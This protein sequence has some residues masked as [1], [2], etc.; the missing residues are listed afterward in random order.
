MG[1][2]ACLALLTV[3]LQQRWG[4]P[5]AVKA[6]DDLGQLGFA[7][8]AAGLC[9]LAS[10]RSSGR[11]RRS[12]AAL[13]V[14][15]AAWGSGQVVWSYYELAADRA[16]PFP[17]AADAG[18]LI[19]PPAAMLALW[20]YPG[21]GRGAR[22]RTRL[23]L[24]GATVAA[25]LLVLSRV[26]TLGAVL[27]AGGDNAF[28][29]AVS[30]SYPLGDL[31]LLTV[32]ILVLAR[33]TARRRLPLILMSCS[34][35]AM[36][37]ADSAFTYLTSTETYHSG[38]LTDLGWPAAFVLVAIAGLV[39]RPADEQIDVDPMPSRLRMFLPYAA[40]PVAAA[41]VGWQLM[42]GR[43]IST[44]EQVT[45]AVLVT[46]IFVR[47]LVTLAENTQLVAEVKVREEQL[48]HQAF[49]DPLTGLPNRSLFGDRLSHAVELHR[50][51]AR[52]VS[53]VIL[54]LDDFKLVN[55]TLGHPAGDELLIKVAERLLACSRSADTVARLGG[56]EFALLLE[57][58]PEAPQVV[59]RRILDAFS[60]PFG[61]IAG[62]IRMSSSV[63]LV[64]DS[65]DTAELSA[66]NI[67]RDADIA[68]YVAKR[69][70]KGNLAVFTPDMRTLEDD[71]VALRAE[72][73]E[74]IEQGQISVAYQPIRD[75]DTHELWGVEALARWQNGR[76]G[77]LT[78]QRFI[79][80]AEQAGL[81]SAIDDSV[82]DQAIRQY[83]IW[84]RSCRTGHLMLSVNVSASRLAD[85]GYCSF[86][87]AALARHR[88]PADRLIME[89]TESTLMTD[90]DAAISI[91]THLQGLGVSVAIDDFGTGYSSLASLDVLPVNLLKV[92]QSFARKATKRASTALVNGIVEM[93]RALGI[94]LIV[95][96]IETV[97]EQRT[98]REAG[99]RLGQGYHLGRPAAAA[100]ITA[101]LDVP[102]PGAGGSQ[103]TEATS[104]V[105]ALHRHE[106]VTAP[107][108]E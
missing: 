62:T 96:G 29:F 46:L 68:M 42:T 30:L 1:L 8:I 16:S 41:V 90:I 21:A 38:A 107:D 69:R 72:L 36:A 78:A 35:A 5:A 32:A 100:D 66:M 84:L 11:R 2:L 106:G 17:S 49:H 12:W 92:D 27:H 83:G 76:L 7:W 31:A 105:V 77:E 75:L 82:L 103:S 102:R 70:G 79:P 45:L 81:I 71:D 33:S 93:G 13:T 97:E 28:A 48:H 65:P 101:L 86:V 94:T 39:D 50:R 87:A 43:P 52:P 73:G 57:A 10:W 61:L 64:A 89:I 53:V 14:A 51:D 98:M 34:M 20:C 3:A 18:Y 6:I 26:S 85:P 95:E 108:L 22:A 54:D 63:G 60:Q 25:S 47:Q 19:F 4:G 9:A 56:D 74:A 67:L 40:L 58:G 80:L 15:L 37:V 91:A 88:V 59:A 44:M 55:D 99:C 104:R 23:V 24:D